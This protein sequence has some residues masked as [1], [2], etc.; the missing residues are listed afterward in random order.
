MKKL[1]YF[2]EYENELSHR[3][4]ERNDVKTL[5]IRTTKN[6]KF[7]SKEY[8]ETYKDSYVFD[9]KG[10]FDE[11]IEKFKKWL[12]EYNFKPDYFL[13]DSEF[14][15]EYANKV[16]RAL[17]LDALTE[18]Q[19]S[20]VRDKAEMKKRFNE[21]GLKTVD[22]KVIKS[23]QDIYDFM[24]KH[25]GEPIILKPRSQM[26]SKDVYKID[27]REDLDYIELDYSSGKYMV[28]SYCP[29]QEW[30][31]ESLVQ[32]G[33]VIDSYVTYIPNRTLWAAMDNKLNCHMTVPKIPDYFKFVPKEFIQTIVDGMNLKD[34]TMTIE[35]F[36]DNDGNVMPSELG[37][38]LPGCQATKN[39]SISYGFD[40]VDTLIDIAIHKKVSLTYRNPIICVGDLYLPNKEGLITEVTSIEDLL[41]MDGVI[42]GIMFVKPGDV[43]EKRRVG[44]DASG[45]VQV[46]GENEQITLSKMQNVFDNFKIQTK[47]DKRR[48]RTCKEKK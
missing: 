32:D 44:N 26:N 23:K 20:W 8:L 19:V 41:C 30:S 6:L 47:K 37:W 40:M 1:I 15:M 28:E 48:E 36:I 31:I 5:F 9:Y 33:K 13:N 16:A 45:W 14:Y 18:E 42:D 12:E 10:N 46:I 4:R 43:S 27:K 29:Y 7:F 11:E 21:M 2:E 38:R 17:K 35:V 25:K 3:L 24:D 22:F 39:H 34:G